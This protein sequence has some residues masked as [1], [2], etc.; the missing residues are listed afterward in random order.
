[1]AQNIHITI[2]IQHNEFILKSPCILR[3]NS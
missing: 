2:T 1:M 3:T